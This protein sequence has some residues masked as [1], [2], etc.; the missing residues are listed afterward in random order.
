MNRL[1]DTVEPTVIDE[2]ILKQSIEEQGPANE[3]GRIAKKEGLDLSE[4][5]SLRLDFKSVYRSNNS[6][7]WPSNEMVLTISFLD[8]LKIDNLWFFNNLVKLNLDNNIIEKIQNLDSL[9]HLEWLGKFVL[10]ISVKSSH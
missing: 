4:V 6:F 9:I 10:F 3:A 2:D 1:Y 5:E 8:I 7:C